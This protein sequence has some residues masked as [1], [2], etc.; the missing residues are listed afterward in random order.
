MTTEGPFE[1]TFEAGRRE[2]VRV[3]IDAENDSRACVGLRVELNVC[4]LVGDCHRLDPYRK[5]MTRAFDVQAEWVLQYE[6]RAT[7][8]ETYGLAG[9]QGAVNL[10]GIRFRPR[11]HASDTL[12]VFMHRRPTQRPR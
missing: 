8:S 7:F 2:Y 10:E 5:A 12:M 4:P 6:E 3:N 1:W 11:G 9:N